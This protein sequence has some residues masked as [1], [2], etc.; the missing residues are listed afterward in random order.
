[1][2][3]Y[4]WSVLGL[5]AW[6]FLGGAAR[7]QAQGC[8]T[9]SGLT[10]ATYGDGGGQTQP[11]Q[12]ELLVPSGASSPVPL[13]IW[14]H[15]GG[16]STGGRTPIPAGVSAL[17]SRGYAVASP[18]YRLATNTGNHWPLQ[19]QDSKAAVR[20]LRANAATYNLDPD[21]VAVWGPSAGGQLAA[22]VGT[23]ADVATF[24]LGNATVDL[25]GTVGGNLDVSSRV[26]A[27]VA[28]YPPVIFLQMRFFPGTTDHDAFNSP[29]SR[30][31]GGPIQDNP[32][33]VA[34]ADPLTFA[35]PDDPPF[36]IMHGTLDDLV[37]F[38]QSELLAAGLRPR[39]VRATFVPVPNGIHGGSLFNT[40]SVNQTV[41]DFLDQVLLTT[42][43][44]VSVEATD[45][46]A[47]EAG[48]NPGAFTIS[49]T[50]STA[51]PLTVRWAL[52][53]TARI[54]RD[55][56]APFQAT[57]PAGAAS[58]DV[59]VR[60]VNDLLV[61]GEETV[62]LALANDPAWRNDASAA[63]ATVVLADNDSGAGLPQVSLAA[64][65]PVAAE[66]GADSGIFTVSLAD[67]APA[68]LT[69]RYTFAGTARNQTDYAALPGTVTVPAGETAAT[70]SVSPVDDALLE[71]TE[72]AIL[73][74]EPSPSYRIGTSGAASVRIADTDFDPAL[75]IVSVA[76]TDPTASEPGTNTGAFQ[77]TRT[78]GTS[79]TLFVDLL[80]DGE[81]KEGPDF[82][83]V[84]NT[85]SFDAG[86]NRVSVNI[87]PASDSLFEGA[88]TVMLSAAPDNAI[89]LG[90]QGSAVTIVDDEIPGTAGFYP[91]APCRLVD[92]RGLFGPRGS[93]SIP[94]D[95]S[96]RV[97]EVSGAC[98]V[99]PEATAVSLNMTVVNPAVTGYLTLFETGGIPVTSTLNFSAGQT[100]ANNAIAPLVDAPR[101]RALLC[102]GAGPGTVDVILDVNG[103]FR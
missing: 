7:S 103:Y 96:V 47:A 94:C 52:G 12:L 66:T 79:S 4:Q 29:E 9:F 22:M 62:V 56:A 97:F 42:V 57:I 33:L 91:V 69:V 51:A 70:I 64:T 60:P 80:L 40:A 37:P 39:G 95:G 31:L 5:A 36:L 85:I 99:A 21:R 73:T 63:S 61:E 48:A 41:Y 87:T 18:D 13:V 58:V 16:W 45:A 98:G 27:V 81:A 76:A 65:D 14:I 72:T 77:V 2:K 89:Q 90:P 1:M 49:R 46:G 17:C 53:G 3:A 15:G 88:E 84:P 35:T 43:P 23:A 19:I 11:L 24:R 101:T 34:T 100:R 30:L 59:T 50:G 93:P 102:G 10:Y 71:S 83:S 28:W 68:D 6:I 8:Q 20:W 82:T 92:T 38:H 55:Y 78:G 74:L 54:S 26:Q 67:P 75:P 44:V 25:Q 32:L 86:V